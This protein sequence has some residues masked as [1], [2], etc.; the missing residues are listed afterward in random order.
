VTFSGARYVVVAT[1]TNYDPDKDYFDTS[2]VE[3]VVGIALMINPDALIIIKSTVPI[4]F[5]ESLSE[6]YQNIIKNSSLEHTCEMWETLYFELPRKK[7]LLVDSFSKENNKT[8]Q[9][10]V[11]CLSHR[12]DY[13]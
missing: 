13:G 12:V 11:I 1:A 6:K 3:E 2:S 10:A 9:G 5:T 8:S 7:D 4:G